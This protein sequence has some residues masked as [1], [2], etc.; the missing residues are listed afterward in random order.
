MRNKILNFIIFFS[1]IGIAFI[2]ARDYYFAPKIERKELSITSPTPTINSNPKKLD[3]EVVCQNTFFNFQK[4][5]SWRYKL[6]SQDKEYFFTNKIIESSPSSV[7][8]ETVFDNDDEKIQTTLYCRKSGIYG[9]PVPLVGPDMPRATV[10]KSKEIFKMLEIDKNVLFMPTESKL[11]LG[12]EW[13]TNLSIKT[14]IPFLSAVNIGI[15]NKVVSQNSQVVNVESKIESTNLPADIIK[16]PKAKI[17]SYSLKENS[18]ITSL[19][20][21]LDLPE[22]GNIKSEVSLID[23]KPALPS[24]SQ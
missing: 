18:G 4:G 15:K 22:V 5:S 7:I 11:K 3:P 13:L 6:T 10:D 16:I 14:S 2:L 24:S 20:L 17:I 12:S 8:L 19:I 23:F 9:L 21:N 1:L